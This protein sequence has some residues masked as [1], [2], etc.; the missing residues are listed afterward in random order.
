MLAACHVL[1]HP[2][3]HDS[4]GVG[5]PRGDG[6][7]EASSLP[8]SRRP[9]PAGD[10]QNG[11]KVP[12]NNPEQ[13]VSELARAMTALGTDPDLRHAM[14]EAGRQRAGDEYIWEKKGDRLDTLYSSVLGNHGCPGTDTP[15]HDDARL[16]AQCLT[17]DVSAFSPHHLERIP[18][19]RRTCPSVCARCSRHDQ[20][21]RMGTGGPAVVERHQLPARP[22]RR[23]DRRCRDLGAF[24]CGVRDIHVFTR[25]RSRDS[26]RFAGR[27]AQC[28][29]GGRMA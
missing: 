19:P 5:L 24:T 7:W 21:V 1:V 25:S 29:I 18:C 13:A 11:V 22:A 6:G 27:P 3:L 10:R 9:S 14:G 12:A 26:R 15:W 16:A 2:S 28:G 20:A 8:R 23:Q 4:G 17:D